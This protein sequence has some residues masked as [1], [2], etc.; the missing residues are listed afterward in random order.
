MGA[1]RTPEERAAW[2]AE[3]KA[4]F[5]KLPPDEQKRRLT[6]L[7]DAITPDLTI[8]DVDGDTL[9]LD[10]ASAVGER[11]LFIEAAT[12]IDANGNAATTVALRFN[13]T[14][15][16]RLHAWLGL[17]LAGKHR[18]P[19]TYPSIFELAQQGAQGW[20]RCAPMY[21]PTVERW[22]YFDEIGPKADVRGVIDPPGAIYWLPGLPASNETARWA[23]TVDEAKAKAVPAAAGRHIHRFVNDVCTCGERDA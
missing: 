2:A 15:A 12:D 10:D 5:A 1:P 18:P 23:A 14:H 19:V 17:W 16:R 4:K 8:E 3:T 22:V 9:T 6:A 20:H 11:A 13:A 7:I 21:D